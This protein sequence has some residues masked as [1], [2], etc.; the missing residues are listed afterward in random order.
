M[1]GAENRV[2][3]ECPLTPTPGCHVT[4]GTVTGQP[5]TQEHKKPAQETST[6][7]SLGRVDVPWAL[8]IFFSHLVFLRVF[9]KKY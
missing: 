2:N 8:G 3:E 5:M 1:Y 6:P 4:T 7:T 9:F